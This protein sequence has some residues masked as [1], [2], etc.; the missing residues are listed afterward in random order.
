MIKSNSFSFCSVWDIPLILSLFVLLWVLRA[1]AAIRYGSVLICGPFSFRNVHSDQVWLVFYLFFLLFFFFSSMACQLTRPPFFPLQENK[2]EKKKI[3][4][5]SSTDA[6]K[7]SDIHRW[8]GSHSV[9]LIISCVC[10][11][12][13]RLGVAGYWESLGPID[14]KI[15]GDTGIWVP[16]TNLLLYGA[17]TRCR[18]VDSGVFIENYVKTFLT[19]YGL[20]LRAWKVDLEGFSWKSTP[21]NRLAPFLRSRTHQNTQNE[22]FLGVVSMDSAF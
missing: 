3:I 16:S 7:T 17:R 11:D 1:L 14:G 12:E 8:F 20:S 9:S 19:S 6:I 15:E 22:D 10:W 21:R 5:N 2:N 4:I 18:S 13:C